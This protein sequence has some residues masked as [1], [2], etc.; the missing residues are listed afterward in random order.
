MDFPRRGRSSSLKSKRPS[1]RT[2]AFVGVAASALSVPLGLRAGPPFEPKPWIEDLDQTR[3]AFAAKY[4][5]LEWAVF[6]REANLSA[7]F[8]DTRTRIE[9]ASSG[10]EA[11]DAFDGLA[12]RLGDGHVRFRWPIGQPTG[13]T[14][15]ANCTALGY[16]PRMQG[17]PV[18]SL[19]PGYAPLRDA[20]APEF[21]AGL[22]EVGGHTIGVVRIGLFSPRGYPDLCAAALAALAIAPGSP[23]DEAC[24]DRIDGWVSARM[25]YDLMAQLHAIKASRAEVLLV[26]I[27]GN[28]GGTEWAE[29]AARMVTAVRLKSNRVGFVRGPHWA[30]AF[31]KREAELRTASQD[32][33]REDRALLMRLAEEVAARHRQALTP[34][35]S[36]PL[37]RGERPTCRWLGEGFYASG[38]LDSADPRILRNKSWA[39]LVFTPM[40]FPY[41]EGVWRGPLIVL[42]NAGTGSAAEEFAAVLQD[43]RAA[44]IIGTPTAGAGCGH[45]E[46]G[47]PTSLKNT[48]ALL[49]LPD[50]ARF[51]A[52]GSNE[53]MGI[54]PDVLVGMR[55][56]DGPHRAGMRLAGKLAEAVDRA[57]RLT[58]SPP[59]PPSSPLQH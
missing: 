35:D 7:L 51:R 39:T 57:L 24:S 45:T 33:S 30:E 26:D 4:A 21:P 38:I 13:N 59:R 14:P 16:D 47:T 8:A 42:V 22:V 28:G 11:R 3:E 44:V 6:E 15:S 19:G 2:W 37:W 27:A 12:R 29:A 50:C 48:G 55:R 18:A 36:G 40:Q 43:N 31:G 10:V 1:V 52:D 9:N 34:C 46:G 23:C 5:N 56:D 17:T 54:Q 32:A 49:E 25:T 20:P 41:D 53:V 58:A